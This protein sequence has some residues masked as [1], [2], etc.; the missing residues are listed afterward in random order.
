MKRF[1]DGESRDQVT[2]LPECLDDYIGEDNSVRVIDLFVDQL[3]LCALGFEG[4]SPAV[5]GRPSYH[6]AIL[7]KIYIY[8]YL[9]R[10]QSSRRLERETQRNVELMWLIHRLKPDFKTVADFR[11]D[12]GAAIRNVCRRFIV[13]CREL[14]LFSDAMIAIDGSKFKAVNNR[15]KNFTTAKMERRMV[16]IEQSIARYLVAMDTADRAEP[17]IAKLKKEHLQDKITAL[18]ERMAALKEIDLRLKASPDQ[19]VSLTDPDARSMKTREGGIVG[20]NVQTAVDAKHHLIVAHE[21]TTDGADRDQLT[22][23]AEQARDATGTSALTVV[24]DR[25]YFKG[26]QIRQ[27]EQAGFMPIVAKPLTSGNLAA[28][29]F[30]KQD[31][32]Y[33]AKD[34]EY[35]CPANQRAIYRSTAVE[36]GLTLKRYWSSAC[37]TCPMK[38][39]CTTGTNRRITRWEHEDVLERMQARLDRQPEMMRVRRQ[40]VEHPFGTLKHWM[41]S[42]HFLTKTLP[43]VS[44]EMSLHV[45]AYNL[46]RVMQILGVKALITALMPKE[47][48]T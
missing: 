42:T 16:N 39:R 1:I 22:P 10:I 7:L 47:M 5:T 19:Q 3:D 36:K 31:F 21:V 9:N 8:G 29:R 4:M 12:N 26:E 14:K 43:R 11:R 2:L 32:I 15:D 23:M 6:P 13:V 37:P 45:L 34:D 25:G 20:Y 44:T 38:A 40:T 48:L 41:G 46:K 18:K 24:A 17:E 30:D 33:I 28:G 27:C 35:R